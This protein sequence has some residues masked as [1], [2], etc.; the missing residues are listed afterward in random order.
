MLKVSG[1]AMDLAAV[2]RAAD[3]AGGTVASRVGLGLSW[4]ALP[5]A[6]GVDAIRQALAP[7]A[8]TVLDGADRVPDPWP[9]IEPGALALMERVKARFD[10]AGA[11]RTGSFMGGI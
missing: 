2:L 9:A 6:T 5:A 8:C 1:R 11:F 4:I 3:A 7:R 10:P